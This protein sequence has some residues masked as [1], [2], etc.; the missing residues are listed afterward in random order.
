MKGFLTAK[1][2]EARKTHDL[3]DLLNSCIESDASFD[4]LRD[5]ARLLVPLATQFRYPGDH[6]EP[7]MVEALE[8]LECATRVTAFVKDRI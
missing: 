3:L 6:F 8:A 4:T 2:I 7:L 1:G 5:D